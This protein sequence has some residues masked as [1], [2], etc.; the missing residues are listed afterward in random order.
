MGDAL[1]WLTTYSKPVVVLLLIAAA[2]LFV[3]KIVVEQSVKASFE[4]NRKELELRLARRSGFED[5]L[6]SQRF[7]T[8]VGFTGR[9]E[10]IGSDINRARLGTGGAGRRGGELRSLTAVYEDLSAKRVV[11][12][13]EFHALLRQK[14]DLAIRLSNAV[15]ADARAEVEQEWIEVDA[16]LR[17]AVDRTFRLS[18]VRA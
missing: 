12:G 6:L 2:A 14:A 11:L 9:L 4:A 15:G 8:V 1:S 17:A 18:E 7:A 13:E 16:R 10:Q 5:R 3:I